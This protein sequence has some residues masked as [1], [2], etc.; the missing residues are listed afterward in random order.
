MYRLS[1]VISNDTALDLIPEVSFTPDGSMFAVTHLKSNEL[2]IFD[3]LTRSVLRVFSNPDALLDG[4][5][6]IVMTHKHI[7]VSNTRGTTRPSSFNI[8]S[9]TSSSD[10]P[11]SVY[12]T[13]YPHLREA[14]TL[15]IQNN[16]LALSLIHI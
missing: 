3:S 5:H 6:G 11:V 1:K 10:A 8:F 4:P 2:V 7:V 13:P 15:T 9:L 16:V 12:E 14:H